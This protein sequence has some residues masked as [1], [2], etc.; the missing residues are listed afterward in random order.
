MTKKGKKFRKHPLNIKK[1]AI[2]LYMDEKLPK[3]IIVSLL[4]VPESRMQLWIKNYLAYDS[5]ELKKGRPKKKRIYTILQLRKISSKIK[6]HGFEKVSK[7]CCLKSK[8]LSFLFV[9]LMEVS[10]TKNVFISTLINNF[11]SAF[12]FMASDMIKLLCQ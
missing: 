10:S 12:E 3:K 5:T 9:S 6:K 1:E 4:G 11:Q 7:P 2:R 8:L